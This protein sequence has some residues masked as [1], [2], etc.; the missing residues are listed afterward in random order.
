MLSG[1]VDL[2]LKQRLIVFIGAVALAV[3]GTMAYQKL[4]ID[5]FPDVAPIQVLVS[6][7]APGLAPEEL[8]SRVTTPIELAARGIPNLVRMRS[9]TR[10]AVALL[11][12]E[13]ADG[14]DIF[15]ARAQ[16]NE[17]LQE[18]R[19]QLPAG[20][21]G[22]LAPIVTPLAEMVMFT[23]ESATMSTQEKRS[24]LDWTIRP[25]LRSL[26]GV[27]DVNV[28]G[29]HVRTF[30]V[31]P[32][33]SAMAARGIT[34][35]M[36]EKAV[37]VNNRNDGAGRIRN[38]EEALLV[39]SE[40]RIQTLDD[41]RNTVVATRNGVI[42]R[43]SDI[44]D[45]R[46]GSLARNG[47]VTADAAGE[48]VWGM[49][50]GLRG[51]NAR[52]VVD[53]VKARFAS[54][55]PQLPEGARIVIFYDRSELIGKAVWTV[56]KV[57]LEAI[58]FVVILLLLFLGNL[59][60]ALVVSLILPLAV[61]TTFGVMRLLG[62]SANIMSLGGLAIAIGLLVD[63]AVVVVENVE[64][65]L[66]TVEKPN[67]ATRVR[68]TLEA[69]R[70]VAVPLVSGVAIII[71]VFMPLLALQGL[72]GRLFSPVAL[73]IVVALI[74]ALLLSLTVV[75]VLSAHLLRT[76]A[77]AEPWLVR[78][79]HAGYDPL[80]AYVMRRPIGVF[81]AVAIGI[82]AV[83]VVFPRIGSTFMPVMDE[84][85]PVITIRKFPTISVDE[86]AQTDLRI[87]QALKA[88]IPE[89]RRVIARAGADEL[90]IDPVGLNETDMFMT[91]AP[92]GEWRGGDMRW[93][94]GELRR[95]LDGIPGISYALTQPIDMRVQEMIIGARGDV[96]VKVFGD[97]IADLNRV[98]RDVASAIRS[99]PGAIDVF[100]LR[101]AGMRYFT[102]AVDRAKAGRFGLNAEEVQEALRVWVDG[103]GL[104]I[105][106][107]GQVRTPLVVRGEERQRASAA[108]L[109]RVPIVLP[110]GGTVELAQVANIRIEDGPI[111][112]IREDGQRFATV[113]ANV[114]G[115]DLVG[116][117]DD[118]KAA[119]AQVALPKGY[120]LVWGG[121][122]ENQQRA[123]ARLSIVVPIALGAIFL[124]LYIT[125]GSLRQAALVFCNVP[126]ASI[127]GVIALWAS[128]EFLSVPASVGFIALMGIAV[129]NGVVMI[130][131]I[132]EVCARGLLPFREAVMEGARRRLRPVTLTAAIA[133]LGLVPF[134]FADGPGA[135]IQRPL[136][137]VVIGGL[138]TATALTLLLI[139]ILYDR[140][141]LPR[142]ERRLLAEQCDEN[143][144]PPE[145]APITR[146]SE[147]QR[148]EATLRAEP[149]RPPAGKPV[150]I[151]QAGQ[152]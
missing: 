40:G 132:N 125:F 143:G 75:P 33:A 119:S 2:A 16:V 98:A 19:D 48:A 130:S 77:H 82:A 15:W 131:Y 99:V 144:R 1:L 65:R 103:R 74:A 80:L 152:H 13:F 147:S 6:M 79:L 68:L 95:V 140:L 58:L 25:A 86:A 107:E 108:D 124:L 91:L 100:A 42:V 39:R 10:Y 24:L 110:G 123:A 145:A 34:T 111:Q 101:N 53:G 30:E 138:I 73:T 120:S 37:E 12:F 90:G 5:A 118:A 21:D 61:L 116:F 46:F 149:D 36:L 20:S 141:A 129:L 8:E 134:L 71:L 49:V 92:R 114:R 109:G 81:V 51:A 57:L 117:V 78:K 139:P 112:V 41:I 113:L 66:S 137:I 70:E 64:H 87:Q 54:L 50:L 126:F 67:L 63:C 14:T 97:D 47:V 93:F 11:T 60:S 89:I 148:S 35:Q 142:A 44:A 106:L 128:G 22:G 96:V 105:V 135:E 115:R 59:R 121:Q 150:A 85:T 88:E 45:V 56:Q 43:V 83:A 3:W 23:I 136:A 52:S 32:S 29:G 69:T 9:T 146:R 17:R 133:A 18:V 76:G 104:G 84:G 28:L 127:G 122:F 151:Q 102:V 38:G 94:L 72:E 55:A 7:Q 27:A 4:P 62:W 31:I 26:P